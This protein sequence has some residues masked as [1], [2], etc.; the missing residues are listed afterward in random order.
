MSAQRKK[1]ITF[2]T[3]RCPDC[4]TE[5]PLSAVRCTGCGN[6]V[7][8]VDAQGRAQK[9]VDWRAYAVCVVS[10]IAFGLYAWWAFFKD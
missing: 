5:L 10:W 6:Q 2:R 8:P 7:G 4:S 9:P 3:K 1:G